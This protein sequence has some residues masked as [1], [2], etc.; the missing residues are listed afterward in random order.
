METNQ[1]IICDTNILIEFYKESPKVIRNLR[2]IGQDNIAV[3]IVTMG[4]LLF[5]ALNKKE[6]DRISQDLAHLQVLS[7]C[8]CS[9]PTKQGL[10]YHLNE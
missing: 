6:L 4:E 9:S 10:G 1:I 8:W 7:L 3:S 5:G 2:A